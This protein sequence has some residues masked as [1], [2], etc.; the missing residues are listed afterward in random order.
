MTEY[1]VPAGQALYELIMGKLGAEYTAGEEKYDPLQLLNMV[2][3]LI[4]INL[5][6]NPVFVSLKDGYVYVS[7]SAVGG[8]NF[9]ASLKNIIDQIKKTTGSGSSALATGEGD[10]ED[11]RM[12]RK[13]ITCLSTRF[14][15]LLASA[16]ISDTGLDLALAPNLMNVLLEN[17]VA[18]LLGDTFGFND[19]V[20]AM[21][22]LS[23]PYAKLSDGKASVDDVLYTEKV[24]ERFVRYNAAFESQQGSEQYFFD[25]EAK[26]TE[27]FIK[28]T[29]LTRRSTSFT[30][31][32]KSRRCIISPTRTNTSRLPRN[33]WRQPDS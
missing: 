24:E 12:T 31:A 14:A 3:A 5:N 29:P 33:S 2:E 32:A 27:N 8:D 13:Q 26:F 17:V 10:G 4:K 23:S 11:K 22:T 21:F 6:G 19:D 18:K 20:K 9:K 16:S 28:R 7:L 15:N 1:L 30:P 25:A